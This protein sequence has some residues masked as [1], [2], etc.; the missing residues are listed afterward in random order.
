ML[1][2][3]SNLFFKILMF[4]PVA[5]D[6][7]II[8]M[9]IWIIIIF[10]ILLITSKLLEYFHELYIKL[11]TNEIK[12]EVVLAIVTQKCF[13]P[14]YTSISASRVPSR[15]N[16]CYDVYLT[17]GTENFYINSKIFYKKVKVGKK[18]PIKLLSYTT[19]KGKVI[20]TDFK[21]EI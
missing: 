8:S 5:N 13:I 20:K 1:K 21:I 15:R 2:E 10:S 9:L 12:E 18:V 16:S 3:I 14:E 19:K 11:K 7:W 17:Y 6:S 4:K